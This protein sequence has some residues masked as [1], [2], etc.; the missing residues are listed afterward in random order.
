M[1]EQQA[2]PQADL[3][4]GR[5]APL[6]LAIQND[7]TD[8]PGLVGEWLAETGVQLRVVDAFAGEAVPEVVPD[9]I[10]GLLPLG[11]AMGANDDDEAPWLVQ[12]RALLKDAVDRGV[13]IL[14]LCLGGQLL[15]A[16]TGGRVDLGPVT[17]IGVV[18]VQRTVEALADPVMAAIEA[19]GDAIPAAQWHQDHVLELPEAAVLLLTNDA[20]RVQ[21]FRL[22]ENA[23]G[24]QMHPEVDAASFASWAEVADAALSRSGRSAGQATA[25]VIAAEP[26]L[27]RV[28]RPMARAWADLVWRY[29]AERR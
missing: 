12:E 13:P 3:V 17:E 29:A 27:I 2:Q 10:A 9:D 8:P 11:G 5:P 26:D 16:A 14:G 25:E 6:V 24:L 28:W 15:A 1:P 18:T 22:G 20:C 4:A 7:G 23:Y 19:P 21:G